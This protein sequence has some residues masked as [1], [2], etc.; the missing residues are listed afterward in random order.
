MKK[1]FITGVFILGCLAGYSQSSNKET[2]QSST[3]TFT[4]F[5][6]DKKVNPAKQQIA[7]DRSMISSATTTSATVTTNPPVPK[8]KGVKVSTAKI[9]SDKKNK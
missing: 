6:A 7:A 5:S 3:M 2:G 1:I 4:K 9:D 8:S